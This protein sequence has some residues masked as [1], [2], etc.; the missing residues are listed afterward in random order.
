MI[1]LNIYVTFDGNCREAM[2]FYAKCLGGDL[3]IMTFGD[4][5]MESSPDTKDKVMHSALR[6]GPHVL[7]A[8]DGKM[9]AGDNF[10]V[11]LQCESA[12]EI[13]RVFKALSEK[14][15]ITGPLQDTFWGARFGTLKDRFGINWM[16]NFEIPKQQ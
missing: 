12:E 4:A 7:M 2:T 15:E 6:K 10:H 11:C 5:P 14:G 8:S 1:G 9:H 16:F 13:E 3:Q